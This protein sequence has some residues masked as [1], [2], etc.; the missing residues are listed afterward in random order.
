MEYR[1]F[2]YFRLYLSLLVILILYG[3]IVYRHAYLAVD[4][5]KFLL[6]KSRARTEREIVISS[7]K[8]EIMDRNGMLL[9][10]SVPYYRFAIDPTKRE[11]QDAEI[12]TLSPILNQPFEVLRKKI[13]EKGGARYVK[14][15]DRLTSQQMKALSD[16]SWE[17]F[18]FEE[19]KGRYYP[20][21]NKASPLIGYVNLDG[22]GQAGVEYQFDEYMSGRD[23]KMVYT[24]NLLNQVTKV[25]EYQSPLEGNPL[26]LT[27]D[28]R[29]QYHTYEILKEAVSYYEAESASLVVISA[30]TGEVMAMVSYPSFDPNDRLAEYNDSVRN[31]VVMDL[32]EPGSVV[33]PLA[34]AAVLEEGEHDENEK[35]D[36]KGGEYKYHGH[37]FKDHKDMGV[38]PFKDLFALSS[39][40]ALIKLIEDLPDNKLLEMYRRFG[41]FS[42]TYVQ[43]PGESIGRHVPDP[44]KIDIAAMSY[45]YGLSVNLLSIARAYTILANDGMDPGV[46]LVFEKHRP[47]AERVVASEIVKQI[48]DMMV[49]VTEKGVSSKRARVGKLKVAGKSSTVHLL[50]SEKEYM[51]EYTATFAG[52]APSDDPL[53]VVAVSI[54]RPKK[55]GHYGGQVAA[56]VFSKIMKIAFNYPP[57]EKDER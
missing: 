3:G 45:G 42:S 55:H 29:L 19:M 57:G 53:F 10:V 9:S 18:I 31:R 12:E 47:E 46:H 14:L 52:F 32:I 40:I 6:E 35:L 8:G 7:E 49:L 36:A 41:L 43:L 34:V 4:N 26:Q 37:V 50:G 13:K 27:I 5:Q 15:A 25:H 2:S 23:G 51:N 48:K 54:N 39:N 20:L 30:K 22:D 17:G 44:G 24:Q 56:P 33:K 1:R 11:Y 28:Y 21:G 38:L 16:L